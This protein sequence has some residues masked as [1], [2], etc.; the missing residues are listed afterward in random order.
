MWLFH[1]LSPFFACIRSSGQCASCPLSLLWISFGCCLRQGVAQTRSDFLRSSPKAVILFLHGLNWNS[2][3]D[4]EGTFI[5]WSISSS[6][7]HATCRV[8]LLGLCL[9]PAN[10]SRQK[11]S[12]L[13]QCRVWAWWRHR[14]Q[15]PGPVAGSST[16]FI[17]HRLVVTAAAFDGAMCGCRFRSARC[18]EGNGYCC[19]VSTPLIFSRVFEVKTA[20]GYRYPRLKPTCEC[21]CLTVRSYKEVETGDIQ[22]SLY[23]DGRRWARAMLSH[24]EG[25]PS[26]PF[27]HLPPTRE[28]LTQSAVSSRSSPIWKSRSQLE[29]LRV[30]MGVSVWARVRSTLGRGYQE[31]DRALIFYLRSW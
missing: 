9:V 28:S 26:W 6:L 10:L 16:S 4:I 15:F 1:C 7:L 19:I 14:Q 27:L 2:A 11:S 12:G 17:D 23:C 29:F 13:G 18:P 22:V 8:L 5:I 25:R 20:L 24:G 30:T 3:S 21:V 31:C